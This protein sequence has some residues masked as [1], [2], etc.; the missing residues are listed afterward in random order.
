M[1][2][3]KKILKW[4]A[5]SFLVL[6]ITL[7]VGSY[8]L[9]VTADMKQPDS[10][11]SDL[12]ELSLQL[13]D[14]LRTYGNNSLLLNKQGLWELYVKGQPFERGVA[15]GKVSEDLL[16]Y[17]EK[18]F[19]DEI[20]KIIPSEKYLKFLRYFLVIFNRNLGE[21]I[22]QENRE[23]IYGISLSCTH[24][25][26]AIGTPYE[27]QLNYHAAHDIGHMMQSYM[28][29]GCSSFGTWGDESSDSTLIIGRNFDFYVGDDFA[30]NKVIAFY[31][32][33]NGYKFASIGWI[34]MTGV[35]SGMNETGLTVTINASQASIPTGAATPISILARIILQYASTIDEAYKIAQ[36]HKTFV[37]ESLLIGSAK[38]GKA[39]IIEKSP[40]EIGIYYSQ[41]N[42][43]VC[44]NH[45]QSD[46]FRNNSK[47]LENIRTTDSDYRF[48]RMNELLNNAG[49]INP[50][51]AAEILR[52]TLG[53]GNK[54]IGLT[55]EKSINQ[56]I[57]HH[58]VIFKPKELKM[59]VST[60]PW[61]LGEY[62]AYDLQDIFLKMDS[63]K[64]IT[65]SV[66]IDK[67]IQSDDGLSSGTYHRV[68]D[69]RRLKDEISQ[70]VKNGKTIDTH[71]LNT[72]IHSNADYYYTYE[73][74]GDYYFAHDKTAEALKYWK[75]ALTKEL[76][77]LD[78]KK[79]IE[80]KIEK[81][82][83]D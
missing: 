81:I 11:V 50:Q 29:V 68:Q 4:F 82:L 21:Y 65:S 77:R 30:K 75:T 48:Q 23:E 33:N 57:A 39:A 32:P 26:D 59:W 63:A 69:Y 78:D 14:S 31:N 6:T 28:L 66:D 2:I 13:G 34:G 45:Y 15:I 47:N 79:N 76:S 16:Y 83:K 1:K 25:F 80:K 22:P 56:F 74:M 49:K 17:Q 5:I 42:R 58:S 64:I 35:L 73:L 8:I 43:I 24:E 3:L 62:I 38:E 52:D 44:T 20:K 27:R 12:S 7:L 9:Y 19:V 60:A 51:N 61:Q 41:Q 40:D 10:D 55:N 36:E 67:I 71:T 37:A 18:V 53:A 70:A 54:P 72:F 46:T